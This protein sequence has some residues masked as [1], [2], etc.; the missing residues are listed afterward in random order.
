MFPNVLQSHGAANCAALHDRVRDVS[1]M[2]ACIRRLCVTCQC[3]LRVM[4]TYTLHVS[5]A[6]VH[7]QFGSPC[8]I[9]FDHVIATWC[10]Q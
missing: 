2:R 1:R 3:R 9:S 10:Y 6:H 4:Y 5:F 8:E 7:M